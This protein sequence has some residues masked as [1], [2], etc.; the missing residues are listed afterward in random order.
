MDASIRPRSKLLIA[1]CAAGSV[2]IYHEVIPITINR[3]GN[4]FQMEAET[5]DW[6]LNCAVLLAVPDM[7]ARS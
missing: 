3:S 5:G 2:D 4:Y 1:A 6:C 7:T